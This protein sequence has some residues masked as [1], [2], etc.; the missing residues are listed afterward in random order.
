MRYEDK[1]KKNIRINLQSLFFCIR[2]LVIC[3]STGEGDRVKGHR[4][5]TGEPRLTPRDLGPTWPPLLNP[6]PTRTLGVEKDTS[7]WVLRRRSL[8]FAGVVHP[9]LLPS[10]VSG[11]DTCFRGEVSPTFGPVLPEYLHWRSV[12]RKEV[13]TIP[14]R[15][16]TGRDGDGERHGTVTR[17]GGG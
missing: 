7:L 10:V 16:R 5:T 1:K 9:C 6:S 12:L 2:R 15:G 8:P 3:T 14:P 17:E 4:R 11:P 13:S